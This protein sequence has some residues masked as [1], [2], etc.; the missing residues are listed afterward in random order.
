MRQLVKSDK[1]LCTGCNRCV[2]E[3]PMETAN[4]TYQDDDGTIKVTI[5]H[6]KCIACG[7]CVSACQHDARFY[8][9]DTERFFSDLN[10]AKPISIMTAPAIRTN[11]PEYK[12]LFTYLK[13]LGVKRIYDVSLGA[14]L[15]IWGYVRFHEK[16][17]GAP[18]ITQ[19]C[20]AI[21][22]YIEMYHHDLL[23]YLSPV[24]SPMA[25][26][27][28]YMKKY[29][30]IT[31]SIAAI[32]PCIAKAHEFEQTELTDYNVTFPKL[33]QYIQDNGIELPEEESDFDNYECGLGS[34]FPMP[35][36]LKENLE[37]FTGKDVSIDRAEG[38]SVYE[39]LNL[40][41]ESPETILPEIFDVLN[42]EE[43]CN[44]GTACSCTDNLFGINRR[45]DVNRK[46]A[47]DSRKREYYEELYKQYDD[48]FELTD[49]LRSYEPIIL[50]VPEITEEDIGRAF[51]RLSKLDEN[52]QK[53]NCGACGSETCYDMA[54]KIA[55]G[56]NIPI[57]CI[58]KVM[59]DA[60][61]EHEENI[62]AQ[63]HI[64]EMER[65]HESAERVRVILDSTPLCAHLYDKESV[66]IDCNQE[67]VKL[68]RMSSKQ[69]YMDRYDELT[70]KHQPGGTVS[71]EKAAWY[72]DRAFEEGYQRFEW[73][74]QLANGE[75]LPVEVTLV[76]V[77][78]RGETLLAAYSRDLRDQKQ[79]IGELQEAT[80]KAEDALHALEAAQSTTAAVFEAN[81]YI[82]I[83]FDSQFRVIDCNP[84]AIE[85]MGFMTRE[86][87]LAGFIERMVKSIPPTQSDGRPSVPLSER[88]VAAS[89]EGYIRFETE[90]ILNDIPRNLDVI[91]ERI[92]Y[93]TSFA[94]VGYVVDMTEV[95]DRENALLTAR[96]LN[97]LQ[98]TKLNLVVQ[99]SKIGLWDMEVNLIDLVNPMNPFVWSDEFRHMLGYT[100]ETDFPNVLHSWSDLLHPEDKEMVLHKFTSHLLDTTGST[101]FDVEFRLLKKD[102][103][104][105]YFR[106]SGETV[107][108][109]HGNALH[110][111]GALL[112]ITETK[113]ILL[114]TERQRVEAEAANQAK[115]AFLS[116]MSH[117][118][119]TPMN[120]ILGITEIQL[121][122]EKLDD[123]LKEALG[124]IYTSGD[125]LLSIINDILDLS[126]IEAGKL[127]LII[128]RF[129]IASLVSDT[130]QLN[131][132][133]IGSKNIEFELYVDEETP[134]YMM[135]DELRVKQILNN[136]LSNA[137]KYTEEG[138][139]TL[140]MSSEKSESGNDNEAVLVISVADTGQGMSEEQVNKLFGEYSRFNLEANRSTEGTG[141]GMSITRNLIRM[142]N[143][144][145]FI[146]SEPKKG[147]TFTVKIPLE[148]SGMDVLGPEMVEN[149]HQFRTSS[150]AQMKRVQVT[151]DP[152]P[153]G[154]VLIVDDVETNIYV[155]KGLMTP[156]GLQID[157]ADSGFAAI[158]KIKNGSE[159]DIVFMD[160]M[161]P[162]M[163]G[164][165]TTQKI[166]AMGYDRAIVALTANAVTGQAE[167]FLGNGF[168]DFISK[169]IDVRQ[170][171]AVL[172]KLIRD[173]Q[174]PEVIEA[175]RRHQ[176]EEKDAPASEKDSAPSIDP[177]FAE[178]FC[179]DA[180]KSLSILEEIIAKNGDYSEEELRTYVIHVHG[181][182]S[183]LANIGNM[184]LSAIALRLEQAGRDSNIEAVSEQSPAFLSSLRSFME[185]IEPEEEKAAVDA[186]DEDKELLHNML[187]AVTDACNDYDETSA[188]KTI[189]ELRKQ[190]WSQ[191]TTDLLGS[192][193]A[194]LL[195]SD[196]DEIL[197]E[198]EAFMAEE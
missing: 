178:I 133:R 102:G 49:F 14:D 170:L 198:I 191:K 8:E 58:H 7:W 81:P 123:G 34:L 146:D 15:C 186:S 135:G 48:L 31:D 129:E 28:V 187:Q 189:S 36:G 194:H 141:L 195:H 162:Q 43:G 62:N 180:K 147:S 159:Y 188:D 80:S 182:K 106:A 27:A 17:G 140:S 148:K 145:I 112:D 192:I 107:R 105:S 24:Q 176:A 130:A 166:R 37:Y 117:E 67:A 174:P 160:H 85:F 108:D 41:A 65:M 70:P 97:E 116:T 101:P 175:A 109:E 51:V 169:P 157:S 120:A 26:L 86:D 98:L 69:E 196:F 136:L 158:E 137:F 95:H 45:M 83:M 172:N 179:R 35:G 53:I 99:A 100:D 156:Y 94:I 149:L 9:D 74:R 150:R 50:S 13:N 44:M 144:E 68:F 1:S 185:Q 71:K 87:L 88:L 66:M 61:K 55:L 82:N 96:R 3:C 139:V 103:E 167:I 110:I 4:I 127:E 173:K 84:A 190:S 152:M 128:A 155:A 56:V 57:N 119:R 52:D 78:Y 76:R 91:L 183:A 193:A 163:D 92:P 121:Q 75:P 32:S 114:D 111:A 73:M 16:N 22:T 104:Y 113:N 5:D 125:L 30:G 153:Y 25:S 90:V 19:P 161:M 18:Q 59:E 79:M 89:T 168:N 154:S 171:N 143:G 47:T 63:E 184:S 64:S 124:K 77:D 197:A 2:R 181:M 33:L 132:M 20:P 12:R 21:V 122:N 42:C 138:T 23:S 40:Y 134:A 115:S 131:M 126:K 38:Q 151:R 165:E 142:M 164:I 93:G 177:H 60:R 46:N 6:D 11:I 72:I 29:E 118:I 10:S 39:K 54:R